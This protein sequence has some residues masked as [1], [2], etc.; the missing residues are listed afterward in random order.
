MA[1][2]GAGGRAEADGEAI[3]VMN[4][5]HAHGWLEP[6]AMD[7]ARARLCAALQRLDRHRRL[8]LYHPFTRDGRPIYVHAKIMVVDEEVLHVGSSNMHNRSLRLD[9]ECDVTMDAD[10]P[11][12]GKRATD[13]RSIRNG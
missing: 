10:R 11:G 7:T 1:E 3:G 8:I 2:G 9:T 12:K 5:R 4:Q 13:S 6:I